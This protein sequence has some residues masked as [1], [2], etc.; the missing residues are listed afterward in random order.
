MALVQ[1]LSTGLSGFELVQ[2][3]YLPNAN[4]SK[5]AFLCLIEGGDSGLK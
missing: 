2:F 4:V 3:S 1:K 5:Q